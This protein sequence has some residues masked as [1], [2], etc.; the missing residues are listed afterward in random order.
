MGPA[1]AH[2]HEKFFYGVSKSSYATEKPSGSCKKPRRDSLHGVHRVAHW[3][4]TLDGYFRLFTAL[5]GLAS[6]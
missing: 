2:D 4:N 5:S 6:P 1:Q 3:V